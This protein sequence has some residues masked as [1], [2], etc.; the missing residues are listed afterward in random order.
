MPRP[1]G[2]P[3][4]EGVSGCDEGES[5]YSGGRRLVILTEQLKRGE[6]RSRCTALTNGQRTE[7]A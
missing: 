5:A 4:R 7:S 3:G 2:W 1:T 6:A